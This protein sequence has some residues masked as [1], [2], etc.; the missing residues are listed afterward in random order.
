LQAGQSALLEGKKL[1][2]GVSKLQ[3]GTYQISIQ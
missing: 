2:K 3:P 1:K